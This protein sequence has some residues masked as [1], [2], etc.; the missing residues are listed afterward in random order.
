MQAKEKEG[1]ALAAVC[2]FLKEFL[3]STVSHT[4]TYACI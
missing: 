3:E 2:I 1:S 4:N